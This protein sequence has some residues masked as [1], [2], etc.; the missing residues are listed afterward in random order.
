MKKFFAV[1]GLIIGVYSL[2]FEFP[3]MPNNIQDAG[4]VFAWLMFLVIGYI[5]AQYLGIFGKQSSKNTE[6]KKNNSDLI[7]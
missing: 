5:S 3:S 6:E 1:L 4:G 7:K 2:I